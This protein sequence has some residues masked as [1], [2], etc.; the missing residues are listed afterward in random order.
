MT[1]RPAMS[2]LTTRRV[3]V[4]GLDACVC[5]DA[6]GS[7]PAVVMLHAA[8]GLRVNFQW[9]GLVEGLSAQHRVIIIDALG[10]GDSDKPLDPAAYTMARR[11]AQVTAVLDDQGIDRA[12]VLGYSMGGHTAFAMTAHAPERLRSLLIGGM[13]PAGPDRASADWG[14]YSQEQLLAAA[15]AGN[16]VAAIAAALADVGDLAADFAAA[17]VPSLLFCGSRDPQLADVQRAAAMTPRTRLLELPELGHRDVYKH[18]CR[19]ILGEL[20]AFLAAA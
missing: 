14:H 12:H 17:D 3:A 10:H 4:P 2:E 1:D 9:N 16:A 18:G 6:C 7:G 8:R 15:R 13:G 19:Q 5:Y 11:V 20:Q